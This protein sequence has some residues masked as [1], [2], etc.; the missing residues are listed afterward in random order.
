MHRF[1]VFHGSPIYHTMRDGQ[2]TAC[3]V[4]IVP[5]GRFD[6]VPLQRLK[7]GAGSAVW[8]FGGA[9]AARAGALVGAPGR[10]EGDERPAT[11]SEAAR[12]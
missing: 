1:A 9:S 7:S 3:G 5:R 11:R 12:A 4:L 8:K 6:A 10:G 2:H